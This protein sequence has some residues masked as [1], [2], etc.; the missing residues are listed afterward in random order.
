[1]LLI[2]WFALIFIVFLQ[3]FEEARERGYILVLLFISI[4]IYS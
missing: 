2:A 4:S 1:M 3:G